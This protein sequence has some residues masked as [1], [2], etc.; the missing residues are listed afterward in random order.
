MTPKTPKEIKTL[1]MISN[2]CSASELSHPI[3][4]MV[5]LLLHNS[6]D[7]EIIT[8]K[9]ETMA[10]PKVIASDTFLGSFISDC[11]PAVE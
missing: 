11:I 3:P 10:K 2:Q 8:F 7:K 1:I 9:K 4:A 6:N 5:P